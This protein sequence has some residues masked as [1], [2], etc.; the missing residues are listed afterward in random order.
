MQLIGVNRIRRLDRRVGC[1]KHSNY[2]KWAYGLC[3]LIV[4]WFMLVLAPSAGAKPAI[5]LRGW[6]LTASVPRQRGHLP[7]HRP[8]VRSSRAHSAIVGGGQISTEQAP[9][10][11]ALL[12]AIPVEIEGEEYILEELCGGVIIGETRVLTAG[13]CMINPLTGTQASAKDFLV[14]A[15]S[16]DLARVEPTEQYVTVA[17][18]RV[19]PYYDYAASSSAPDADDIAVLTLAKPLTLSG[20]TPRAIGIAS[21]GSMVPEGMFAELAGFGEQNPETKELN[22]RLYSLGMTVGFPRRCGGEADAVFVCASAVGG[23]GCNG[24]S[25]GGLTSG[26]PATLVAVIDTVEVVSGHACG[27]GAD[28][29]FANVDAPEIREFIEG[30]ASPLRAPRGGGVSV[31]AVPAVGYVATCEPGSWSGSPTYTY[32]FVDSANGQTLQSGSSRVYE[33]TT[34]DVGRGD[35][36]SGAGHQLGRHGCRADRSHVADRGHGRVLRTDSVRRRTAKAN[37][38]D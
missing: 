11:V 34:A 38:G 3:A 23:S 27:D 2:T 19:H 29:G 6:K 1:V 25:G 8:K 17:D 22:G 36:L 31:R 28:N 35:L 21:A 16:A 10:Q 4:L 7:T 20:V 37:G 24:D 13:H 26:S 14:V 9:W 12:G 18:V 33:L 5:S 30:N 15:G 32:T